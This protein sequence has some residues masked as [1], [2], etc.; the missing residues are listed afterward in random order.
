[1]WFHKDARII[2]FADLPEI[3]LKVSKNKPCMHAHVCL[4]SLMRMLEQIE[5]KHTDAES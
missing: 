4:R 2:T 3:R 1:M 5:T